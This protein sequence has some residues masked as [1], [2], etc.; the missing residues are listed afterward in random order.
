MKLYY[1]KL[2]Y[3]LQQGRVTRIN[4]E[5][6]PTNTWFRGFLARHSL[7]DRLAENMDHGRAAMSTEAVMAEFFDFF[8]ADL[9]V[10]NNLR[11]KPDQVYK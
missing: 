7:T 11:D 6:G 1:A 4:I 3:S 2:N 5:T 10:K 8:E 9:L